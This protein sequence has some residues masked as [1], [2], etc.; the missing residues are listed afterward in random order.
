MELE[1]MWKEDGT[2]LGADDGAGVWLLYNMIER[3][4]PGTYLFTTGE[5]RGGVGAKVVRDHYSS[6][7]SHFRRAI[8]F[9][10]KGTTSVISHQ[11]ACGRCCSDEFAVALSGALSEGMFNSS[12]VPECIYAPDSGGVYTDTAEFTQF[13]PECTNVSAGY[14]N[15][16][17]GSE[18]LDVAYLKGLL[19]TCL[20]LKWEDLPTRRDPKVIEYDDWDIG[21]KWWSKKYPTIVGDDDVYEYDG[22]FDWGNPAASLMMMTD[23]EILEMA[24]EDPNWAG[25]MLICAKYG[26]LDTGELK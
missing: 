15:E 7:L 22:G 13:I 12:Y 21:P 26:E 11:M 16:H 23:E 4:V 19:E 6:F 1:W 8:T 5:E 3:G 10:R 2:A 24:G 18:T 17:G 20:T 25:E 9:D 14:R